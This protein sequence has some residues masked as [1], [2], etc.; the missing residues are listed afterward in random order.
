M[1]SDVL[2]E[3][4]MEIDRCLSDDIFTHSYEGEMRA[5]IVKLR[6]EIE[7]VRIALDT[8]PSDCEPT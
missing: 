1:I 3:A 2:A 8:P 7:A 5:R 4:A 6:H